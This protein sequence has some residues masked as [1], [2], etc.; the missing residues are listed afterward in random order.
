MA[1][2][3]TAGLKLPDI[4]NLGKYGRHGLTASPLDLDGPGLN[5]SNRSGF[6]RPVSTRYGLLV[7]PT[8]VGVGRI[9]DGTVS[10]SV[11][12]NGKFPIFQVG[13]ELSPVPTFSGQFPTIAVLYRYVPI[14][15]TAGW[16][17]FQRD[18]VAGSHCNRKL[19][20]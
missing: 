18:I 9:K 17:M 14:S 1:H 3:G 16:S 8:Q 19:T 4:V 5:S 13:I 12:R 15:I 10:V 2:S 6:Y 20:F 11:P 7:V